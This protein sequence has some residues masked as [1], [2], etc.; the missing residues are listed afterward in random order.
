MA[1]HKMDIW[2]LT[3]TECIKHSRAP[4][5]FLQSV[6]GRPGSWSAFF[7]SMKE[8]WSPVKDQ[9]TQQAW[10]NRL[11]RY[12]KKS[13]PTNSASDDVARIFF[14]GTDLP[15][16]GN[17]LFKKRNEG[18]DTPVTAEWWQF[19]RL[20]A[21]FKQ[22][23]TNPKI[24]V[25]FDFLLSC[26]DRQF[27]FEKTSM[28]MLCAF[29]D[30]SRFTQDLDNKPTQDR[31]ANGF[32][33]PID[34]WTPVSNGDLLCTTRYRVMDYLI[35]HRLIKSD[36]RNL[37]HLRGSAQW[38]DMESA[39]KIRRLSV[40]NS[41]LALREAVVAVTPL[42]VPVHTDQYP[43]LFHLVNFFEWIQS[44]MLMKGLPADRIEATFARLP[45][46]QMEFRDE[47]TE[48]AMKQEL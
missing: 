23:E 6:Y 32:L 24:A 28:W 46:I 29:L 47:L 36:D 34:F 48:F 1:G 3:P 10:R 7:K 18:L 45:A 13:K 27:D 17:Q 39:K 33:V 14:G 11:K 9:V 30:M 15:N 19:E 4:S 21:H 38:I 25:F 31:Y 40:K 8:P 2:A 26:G 22:S 20:A 44:D 37:R 12:A 43:L 41:L 42:G 5:R 35:D 16:D